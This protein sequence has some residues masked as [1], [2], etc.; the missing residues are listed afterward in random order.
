MYWF[1]FNGNKLLRDGIAHNL[2]GRAPYGYLNL[3]E[4]ETQSVIA[5]T[6]G[7]CRTERLSFESRLYP[8]FKRR[9]TDKIVLTR[10]SR[11]FLCISSPAEKVE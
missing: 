1:G 2:D 6:L 8:L 5:P 7:L 11:S 4:H 9:P 3:R 10:S